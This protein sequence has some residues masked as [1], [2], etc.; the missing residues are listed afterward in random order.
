MD[1]S[2]QVELENPD[3]K[4]QINS[5]GRLDRDNGATRKPKETTLEF[6]QNTLTLV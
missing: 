2:Q 3:L 6:S 1:L 4:Q 5:I